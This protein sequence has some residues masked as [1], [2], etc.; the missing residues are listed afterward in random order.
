[1]IVNIL[2]GTTVGLL[3]IFIGS[4]IDDTFNIFKGIKCSKCSNV[5][6]SLVCKCGHKRWNLLSFVLIGALS[7]AVIYLLG[8]D[9]FV[10]TYLFLLLLLSVSVSDLIDRIVPD[11]LI[12]IFLPLLF[13]LRMFYPYT[14]IIDSVLGGLI[15]FGLFFSIAFIG[16][17]LTKQEV[18]GGGDIK[19]YA[20]IGVVLGIKLVLL[21]IFIASSIGWIYTKIFK[22]KNND[23]LPF[24]PFIAFGSMVSY[25]YG[26]EI[27]YWY[28]NLF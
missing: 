8:R 16:Q 12:L 27:L 13:T 19:L 1:M 9:N 6:Y 5:G 20:I 10:I 4:N 14:T 26:F 25:I 11:K 24:V 3:S 17:K 2:I 21:S 28:F 23:Y 15:A 22:Y 7:G 18:L